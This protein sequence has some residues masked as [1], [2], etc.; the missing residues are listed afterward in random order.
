[1]SPHNAHTVKN[2]FVHWWT[3]DLHDGPLP[4][5]LGVLALAAGVADAVSFLVLGRTFVANMTGNFVVLGLGLGGVKGISLIN[6]VAAMVSFLLVAG[7]VGYISKFPRR[8]RSRYLFIMTIAELV[9]VLVALGVSFV[10]SG[11]PSRNC[12]VLL[13]IML[14]GAMGLQSAS[15]Q[16]MKVANISTTYITAVATQFAAEITT[17]PLKT[18]LRRGISIVTRIAGALIAALLIINLSYR[19]ALVLFAALVGLALIGAVSVMRRKDRWQEF[20]DLSL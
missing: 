13:T 15:Q 6:T 2:I 5:L 9:M 16:R 20:P 7:T 1:M 19:W 11:L 10:D 3:D 18:S 4:V 17:A 8:S 12:A 14:G